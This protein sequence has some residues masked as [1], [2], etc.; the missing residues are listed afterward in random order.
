MAARQHSASAA[1]LPTFQRPES[2]VVIGEVIESPGETSTQRTVLMDDDGIAAFEPLCTAFVCLHATCSHAA[3]TNDSERESEYSVE[4]FPAKQ[5]TSR[6]AQVPDQ[7]I[8]SRSPQSETSTE[9]GPREHFNVVRV[10]NDYCSCILLC[11]CAGAR[12][13]NLSAAFAE[14][15]IVEKN[16]FEF[17]DNMQLVLDIDA[18]QRLRSPCSCIEVLLKLRRLCAA[19]VR[20]ESSSL[21]QTAEQRILDC[22][23]GFMNAAVSS[24]TTDSGSYHQ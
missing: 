3:A 9:T 13:M 4:G 22:V 12:L 16:T 7:G 20:H 21:F 11:L 23:Q 19:L 14:A 24:G 18:A 8:A 17:G 10:P 2:A 1:D 15:L 5:M 6:P